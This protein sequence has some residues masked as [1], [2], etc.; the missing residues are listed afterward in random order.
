MMNIWSVDK[1]KRIAIWIASIWAVLAFVVWHR[2]ENCSSMFSDYCLGI[3]EKGFL[4]FLS[5]SWVSEYQT[6]LAGLLTLAGAFTVIFTALYKVNETR[7]DEAEKRR[8]EIACAY[9]AISDEFGEAAKTLAMDKSRRASG[10]EIFALTQSLVLT[11]SSHNPLLTSLVKLMMS[12]ARHSLASQTTTDK[13][14]AARCFVLKGLL[15]REAGKIADLETLRRQISTGRATV[16][17]CQQL[18]QLR[19]TKEEVGFIATYFDWPIDI[20]TRPPPLTPRQRA[21]RDIP[22]S[23][24]L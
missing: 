6:L 4:K 7:K 17:L 21:S 2:V 10:H 13:V 24:D 5:L 9:I 20:F 3:Y 18:Q 19:V 15:D 22:Q 1:L 23:S 8:R 14:M 12:D 11:A 16:A